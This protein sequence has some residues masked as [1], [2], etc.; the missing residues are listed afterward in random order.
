MRRLLSGCTAAI[1]AFTLASCSSDSFQLPKPDL[2][3]LEIPKPNFSGNWGLSK[4]E[5]LFL[6]KDE[7][8]ARDVTADELIRADG[9]CAG[10]PT[11]A[12]AATPFPAEGLSP[13]A[14]YFQAGPQATQPGMPAAAP[15]APGAPIPQ[16]TRGVGLDMTECEVV[17][18][19]GYTDRIEISTNERG[20]RK[21]VLTYL[22]GD[23]PGIYRFVAGRLSS[24]E[25][26]PDAPAP[27][28]PS[29]P[30]K[31]AKKTAAAQKNSA[32]Q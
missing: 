14:L 5:L 19:A 28:K 20:Q 18:I 21:V 24:I 6:K 1:V 27:A 22:Q 3:D 16:S 12:P 10:D 7:P 4:P 23:R 15:S 2:P 32:A 30:A 11:P 9:R 26:S 13:Q 25:R 31:P 8:K 29:K 17:R